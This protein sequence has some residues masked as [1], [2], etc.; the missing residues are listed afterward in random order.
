MPAHKRRCCAVR[1]WPAALDTRH[2]AERR[3][4]LIMFND[5]SFKFE[6]PLKE[7]TALAAGPCLPAHS[8][9]C[10]LL[11]LN[12]VMLPWAAA[13]RGVGGT[14]SGLARPKGPELRKQLCSA[15]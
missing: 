9:N 15:Q 14:R 3:A 11:C 8:G 7:R 6:N 12:Y 5:T 13:L 10:G 4:W 1:L 2:P